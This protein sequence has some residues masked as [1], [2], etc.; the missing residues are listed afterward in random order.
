MASDDEVQAFDEP[1][2]SAVAAQEDNNDPVISVVD[3]R[4]ERDIT[5]DE[6][7]T[8]FS[9]FSLGSAQPSYFGAGSSF[10]LANNASMMKEKFLG[11]SLSARRPYFWEVLP[12]EQKAFNVHP[13][14]EYPAIDLIASLLDVYFTNI[15]P[16]IPIL[17]RPTFERSVAEG[18]HFRDAEFGGGVAI[19]AGSCIAG[20]LMNIFSFVL[21]KEFVQLS[22]D[23]RV[24]V[25]SGDSLSAGWAF[26]N[27]I[28]LQTFFEPT[29]H[30]V[31]MCCLLC[32]YVL[33]SSAPQLCWIYTGLGTRCLQHRGQHRPK[34][35]GHKWTPEDELWKRAFWMFVSFE[36]IGAVFL[37]RPTGLHA[38][39]YDVELPLEVD[40]EYWDRGA[41]QPL[42]KP[43]ELSYFVCFVRVCE[44]LGDALR[45]L[46]GSKKVKAFMG[47]DSP[48][49]EQQAV[50]ELDSKMNSFLDSI[51]PH[52]RWDP[53]NPPQGIFFDQ[54]AMLH[55]TYNYIV[56]AIHRRYI[57]KSSA[58]S[59]PSLTICASAARAILHTADI[60]LTNLQR[61]PLNHITPAL[62]QLCKFS[63]LL[64]LG[65][66]PPGRLWELLR[67]LC[68]DNPLPPQD[69]PHNE[70]HD[71]DTSA[72][73]WHIP[74]PS[75]SN[76]LDEYYPQLGQSSDSWNSMLT[77]DQSAGFVQGM[78]IEQLLASDGNPSSSIESILDDEL[79]SMWATAPAN[80]TNIQHWG[81]FMG[82]FNAPDEHWSGGFGV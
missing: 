49:W 68:L 39:E 58:Q 55:I 63:S 45:R 31:Q 34:P 74:K 30:M 52:L 48:E 77:H 59:A 38:E 19:G 76:I 67:E 82:N 79:M 11:P 18:L 54:S 26:A 10:A 62:Q 7:A 61:L 57:Q 46:Y 23:P 37:G 29:I 13:K 33:G 70:P 24:F 15:H 27:Q 1:L 3:E 60:W 12:W 47:W 14:Y 2:P 43:S 66:N 16:T 73:A 20:K 25:E 71:N 28:V 80:V 4:E 9:Q 65:C 42:G 72:S 44:I 17:H 36:H 50:A 6:L 35:E 32:L 53:E 81:A 69:P 56:I 78:S 8:R 41:V 75:L 5:T 51:P 21:E 64:N 22:K 40:D